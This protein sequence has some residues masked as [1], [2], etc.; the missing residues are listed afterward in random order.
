[1]YRPFAILRLTRPDGS[2]LVISRSPVPRYNRQKLIEDYIKA[3]PEKQKLL[4]AYN[5]RNK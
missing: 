4:D 5:S 2:Q 3:H 1:M